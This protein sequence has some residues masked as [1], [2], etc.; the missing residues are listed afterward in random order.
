ML[1]DGIAGAP[2]E[3]VQPPRPDYSSLRLVGQIEPGTTSGQLA[4]I[5]LTLRTIGSAPITLDPCPAYAGRDDATAYS[6]GFS[7]PISSGYLPCTHHA[8]V[9][10]PG[11]PLHWTIP[12]TSLLQ[13]PGTGAIP[14]STVYVQLGVAG[15]PFLHL[16]TTAYR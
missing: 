11:H 16:K 6:G 4:P 7:D 1:I 8:A 15:V 14:G 12:A 2:G 9:I 13:T 10:R 5:D 3:P